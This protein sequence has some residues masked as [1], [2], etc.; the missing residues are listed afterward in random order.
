MNK[1]KIRDILPDMEHGEKSAYTCPMHPQ[2]VQDAPGMCP[3]CGMK[4]VLGGKRTRNGKGGDGGHGRHG[5]VFARKFWGSLALTLPVLAYSE[6]L[7]MWFGWHAPEFPGSRWVSFIFGTAIFLYGGMVFL[8]SAWRE[9][10]GRSPGMMTL[11]AIAVLAAYVWSTA[12]T[13]GVDG[14]EF[15]WELATLVTIMLLGHWI[16]MR[17]VQGAQGALRELAK[18]LP[19]M[20]EL[21]DGSAIPVA[22]LK[23]GD[24]VIVRPGG[25]IPADG[26]V[27]EG[28]S[29]VNESMLTG[30]SKPVEK[31]AGMGVIAGTV[32][33]MGVL[34]V[35]ITKVGEATALAGIMRLVKDAQRSRSRTQILAD[36]AAFWLTIV[37]L[38][39]AAA[40]L[41]GWVMAGRGIGFALERMVTV[42]IIAC[43]HA[44]GLAV[45]LVVAI[46]TT[47]G[48][49]KGVLVRQRTALEAARNIDLVLFDKTGTLTRGEH[50]VR[51]MWAEEGRDEHEVLAFAA[52][53]ERGSEHPLG[54]AI[55]RHAQERKVD[56]PIASMFKALP[57]QGIAAKVLGREF[58][59]GGP[60]LLLARGLAAPSAAESFILRSEAE[61][62]T[63]VYLLEGERVFGAIALADT[64]REESKK[65]VR[66][67]R[68]MGVR[69]AM[70]T[71]D[72]RA[73]AASVAKELGI[74]EYFAEVLPEHKVDKVKEV[75]KDGSRV[76]MVGDGVNDAPALVRADVG[77]AIGAGT[78][79][80]IESAGIILMRSNPMDIVRVI[81][82]SRAT[83]RKMVQNLF[84]A[85]GYNIVAIPLAAGVL[86]PWGI[87]LP[88]ALGAVFMSLSTVIVAANAVLLRN[89]H[90]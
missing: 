85:T 48:A 80:A 8:R 13:L 6:M 17:S 12:V 75:Q 78:D 35:E 29:E 22:E 2:I 27:A 5:N 70:L 81:R 31:Q 11:I 61:G 39:V 23:S 40:T 10:R 90:I 72:S 19:D 62:S 60:H 36:R 84:W 47:L 50:G 43:P 64:V 71:G 74:E 33:G 7:Q 37:A 79:V 51:A 73:V 45:P 41:A 18:L 77:V 66:S 65:A 44:L 89:K 3:E 9:V 63:V 34:R 32:N 87:L 4:L 55:V 59:I 16:E 24:M 86:A 68:A 28:S 82:L 83:Y 49:R 1:Y 56:I 26:K 14:E 53:A 38:A 69:V 42:L 20:A 88:P 52:A 58:L 25:K 15:F 21:E 67:L 30:E 54:K 76:M 57:G 46:S